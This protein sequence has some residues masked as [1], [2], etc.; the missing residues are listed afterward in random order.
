M[1]AVRQWRRANCAD[2]AGATGSSYLL[3]GADLG[4][5]IQVKETAAN[6]AGTSS[7]TSMVTAV[8]TAGPLAPTTPLLDSFNRANGGVGANWALIK[9]SGFSAMNIAGNAAVDPSS[10]A[11]AWNYWKA[12]TFGPDSEAYVTISSYAAGDVIRI[13]ARVS[14][15]GTNSASGYYVAVSATGVWSILRID[16]GGTPV[17]LVSGVTQPLAAGDKLAIRIVGSLV[18]AL[19]C[20]TATAWVRVLSYD[21][22]QDSVRYTAAGRLAL[23]FRTSTVDDFG[24]GT[25]P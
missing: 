12:A 10:T 17:T 3:V 11:F 1:A 8:V 25:I 4:L 19:H 16:N 5:T 2:I 22:S 6:T 13:G 14:G 23:E 21:T 24:G 15:G 18:T 7:A 9:P 20:T